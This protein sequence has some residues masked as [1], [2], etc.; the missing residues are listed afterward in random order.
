MSA[1]TNLDIAQLQ[2]APA[3]TADAIR[4]VLET[5]HDAFVAMDAGG[6]ITEWNPQAEITFGWKREEA[7]GRALAETIIPPALRD[8]HRR[9]LRRF[10]DTGQG[11]ALEKRLELSA[12]HRDGHEFP[13][14]VTI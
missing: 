10:L 12:L 9:G 2:A 7:L 8:V 3:P 4:S 14:E 1:R 11:R 5:A 6:R 13:V